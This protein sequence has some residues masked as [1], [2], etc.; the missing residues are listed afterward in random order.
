M[1][2]LVL[3]FA[4]GRTWGSAEAVARAGWEARNKARSEA[5]LVAAYPSSAPHLAWQHARSQY[6]TLR[7]RIPWVPTG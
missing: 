5:I 2:G 3:D 4:P 7:S 6:R 1:R